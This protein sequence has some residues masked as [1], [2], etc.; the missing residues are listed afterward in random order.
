MID[1]QYYKFIDFTFLISH[2][3]H[4]MHVLAN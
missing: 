3:T 4:N 2:T 1:Y